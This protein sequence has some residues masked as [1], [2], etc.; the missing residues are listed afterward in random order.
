M[1]AV[2]PRVTTTVVA[3][4]LAIVISGCATPEPVIDVRTVNVAV[5]VPCREPVPDRPAM[6]TE[7]LEHRP[8]LDAFVAAAIAEIELREGYE[9]ELR[10]ALEGCTR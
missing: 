4:I 7:A 8:T 6:P 5:P 3:N 1:F 10:T 2:N 9:L